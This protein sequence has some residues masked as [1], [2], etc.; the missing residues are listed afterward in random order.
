VAPRVGKLS[1]HARLEDLGL[2]DLA[3]RPVLALL[4]IQEDG[5]V[6]VALA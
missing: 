3:H 4:V 5:L 6:D 1:G 2:V